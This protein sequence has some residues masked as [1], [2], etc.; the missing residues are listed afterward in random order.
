MATFDH[1]EVHVSNIEKYCDFLMTIFEGGSY[2]V[3]SQSGTSM[4]T[5][6]DGIHIE[7]KKKKNVDQ[8]LEMNGFCNPC[9]RRS[10]PKA[11]ILEL[12]LKIESVQDASFGKVYFFKDHEGVTW[13]IKDLPE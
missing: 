5:S 13:H 3:I 8:E 6:A 10:D 7:V 12:G 2:E 11:L 1:I 4:F 9:M